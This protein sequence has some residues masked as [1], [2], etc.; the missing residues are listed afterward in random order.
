M[1]QRRVSLPKQVSEI[2][3]RFNMGGQKAQ[4][5]KR[6]SNLQSEKGVDRQFSLP[7]GVNTRQTAAL[8]ALVRCNDARI[9]HRDSCP[10][11]SAEGAARLGVQIAPDILLRVAARPA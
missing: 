9:A 8:Q 11:L 7:V 2:R 4:G 6:L 1:G 3:E 10:N 5:G